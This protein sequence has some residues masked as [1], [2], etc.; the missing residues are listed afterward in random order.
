MSELELKVTAAKFSAGFLFTVCCFFCIGSAVI[1]LLT[2][3]EQLFMLKHS[4]IVSTPWG[5]QSV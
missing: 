1:H 3:L 4:F 5:I 2:T